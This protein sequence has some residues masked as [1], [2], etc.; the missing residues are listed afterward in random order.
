MKYLF[1]ILYLFAVATAHGQCSEFDRLLQEGDNYLKKPNYQEAINSYT[2]AILACSDRAGEAKQRIT[3]MVNEIN[4]LKESAVVAEKQAK[5]SKDEAVTALTNLEKALADIRAKN[6]TT[7]E[8]FASL[9]ANL[10][11]TLDH[12][13][14]LERMKVAVDIEVDAEVK[15]QRL[16]EPISELLYFF[17]EGGRRPVL[18]RASAE[19]LLRLT[20]EAR[21]EQALR[22]CVQES[23]N[24]RSQFEPLLRKLPSF[25]QFQARYYPEL[26]AVPLGADSIFE[27][28][29]APDE[30]NSQSDEQLHQVKLSAYKIATTPTTF[31]QFA[32]FCEAA[33]KR[34]ASRTPYW[35]RFG[36]H[37]A[38]NV[39]W[40][41]TLEYAN[42]L[43]R[44]Q[45]GMP[46]YEILKVVNSDPNN[47]V[48]DDFL[49]WK[50]TWNPVAKG[51]RLPTEAEWEL[52]A[53]AGVGAKRTLFAGS[54]TLDV[55]G[56]YWENSGDKPLSGD[57]DLNGIYDNNGR[58]HPVKQKKDNGIGIY[59]MSGNLNQWCWD[60][61]EAEYYNECK[62]QGITQNPAGA[63]SSAY[64]RVFR[65]GS[66]LI[67]AEY[68][69]TAFRTNKYPDS[70]SPSIG[71]RLVFVP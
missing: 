53:Q 61:Y 56:W 57:W 49:K 59:D 64:G 23:W 71:F 16:T 39:D 68:C 48:R 44:Q 21:L 8:S 46:P 4:K 43:N 65:G 3:R 54:N 22:Q 11:Y 14:A 50:V 6:L 26:V 58:T 24:T 36:D 28:G 25:P 41:E 70:R 7:F 2:A 18:A 29:S 47:Q 60:W 10:I 37:P 33:D 32:L 67:N 40:Y 62:K 66:W 38:V 69:R 15:R 13:E 27:M 31:Y 34:L 17:A 30:W 19:L 5:K 20:P 55:V 45:G 52:A 51:F 63:K 12:A 9:G 35:G 1:S 42:W